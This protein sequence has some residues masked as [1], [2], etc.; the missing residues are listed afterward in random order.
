MPDF[1]FA[2]PKNNTTGGSK[3]V[4]TLKAMK[5][6]NVASNFDRSYP[7]NKAHSPN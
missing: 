6:K 2:S 3:L 1:D 4:K 7:F 5:L